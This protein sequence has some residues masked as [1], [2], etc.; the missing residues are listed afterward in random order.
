MSATARRVVATCIVLAVLMVMVL[1]GTSVG[2]RWHR[3]PRIVWDL[4]KSHMISDLGLASPPP[5]SVHE[6]ARDLTATV[7][8]PGGHVITRRWL[9]VI[10]DCTGHRVNDLTLVCEEQ[11]A[12]EAYRTACEFAKE[13]Q[14]GTPRLARWYELARINSPLQSI[15]DAGR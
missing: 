7:K 3:S 14:I 15:E 9:T 10:C 5:N 6:L 12:D 2:L 1:I 11:T 13:W 4:S 8:L